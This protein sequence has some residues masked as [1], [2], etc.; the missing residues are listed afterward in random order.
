MTQG[1]TPGDYTFDT[2]IMMPDR[3]YVGYVAGILGNGERY[4]VEFDY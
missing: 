2:A 4:D 1:D 3:T